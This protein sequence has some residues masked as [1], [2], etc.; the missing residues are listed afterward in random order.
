MEANEQRHIHHQSL[1]KRKGTHDEELAM[2]QIKIMPAKTEEVLPAPRRWA[3]ASIILL[4]GISSVVYFLSNQKPDTYDQSIANWSPYNEVKRDL[5]HKTK[6]LS[7]RKTLRSRTTANGEDY[8]KLRPAVKPETHGRK[9]QEEQLNQLVVPCGKN[10]AWPLPMAPGGGELGSRAIFPEALRQKR[11]VF[12]VRR[13]LSQK[14][15]M[16]HVSHSL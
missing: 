15:R 11:E 9:R 10:E 13:S 1:W 7:P 14:S 12:I 2:D 16:M 4:L 8:S 6:K 5:C 3:A